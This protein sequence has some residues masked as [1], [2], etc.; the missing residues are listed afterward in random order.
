[1]RDIGETPGATER[2]IPAFVITPPCFYEDGTMGYLKEQMSTGEVKA[3]R[4]FPRTSRFPLSHIE[5]M[6]G[7]LKTY[8]PV[9]FL[10]LGET[11][12]IPDIKDF[13]TMAGI[14]PERCSQSIS[15]SY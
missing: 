15:R 1:M 9:V 13:I 11:F 8:K 6:L 4:I 7:E 5:R 10:D 3:L 12:G 2:I 14:F